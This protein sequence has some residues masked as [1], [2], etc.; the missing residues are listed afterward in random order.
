MSGSTPWRLISTFRLGLALPV[1][2]S[3][4]VCCQQSPPTAGP[5]GV[6]LVPTGHAVMPVSSLTGFET[7]ICEV[8]EV[9]LFAAS[10]HVTHGPG[11]AVGS[12]L[13]PA[14]DGSAAFWLGSMLRLGAQGPG[15]RPCPAK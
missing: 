2:R 4:P 1:T 6:G 14:T 12:V 15:P 3:M 10:S 9:P 13:P 5:E 7:K 8:V 11:G